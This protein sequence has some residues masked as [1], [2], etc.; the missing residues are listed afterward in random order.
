MKRRVFLA[1]GTAFV[2][3]GQALV[4]PAGA[5][6]ADHPAGAAA[7]DA[8]HGHDNDGLAHPIPYRPRLGDGRQRALVLGGGGAYLAAWMVGY[9]TALKQG[10]VDLAE[11]DLAVG[12]SA[13]AIMGASL[14]G[15]ELWRLN[16]ELDL[17][18]A[19]PRLF[20]ALLPNVAPNASQIRARRMTTNAR[21]ATPQVIEAIGRAAMAARNAADSEAYTRTIQRLIGERGWPSAT[22]LTTANDCYTGER[23]VISAAD[24]IS[25]E[26]ACAASS[27][28]PGVMG[29][30]WLHDRLCMDGGM[31]QTSTHADVVAGARRALIISLSD[32]SAAAVKAGL[33]TSGLPNTL[34]EEVRA[35]RRQGTRTLLKVVGL[36]PG[37]PAIDSIMDPRWIAPCLRNGH[38]RGMADLAEVRE[39][40]S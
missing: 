26:A 10:G 39:F 7:G 23:L 18:A 11:A 35:L 37:V 16:A 38:E 8:V 1:A 25:I 15:G 14:L 31:C 27:S 9:F 28:L 4:Q 13:G 24:S 30:T 5:R 32:G 22:L 36:L 19:F 12:T 17:L 34:M 6:S 40:W 20:S 21:G 2:A 33:R 29:P 3:A